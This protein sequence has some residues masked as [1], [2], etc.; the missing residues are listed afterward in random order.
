[1]ILSTLV[2]YHKSVE[3]TRGDLVGILLI[4]IVPG[5]N[6]VIGYLGG[7]IMICKSKKVIDF[8]IQE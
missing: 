8:L 5:L 4:A 7:L 3:V 1:M 2:I 6:W